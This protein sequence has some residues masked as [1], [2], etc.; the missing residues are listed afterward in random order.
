MYLSTCVFGIAFVLLGNVAPN[1]ISFGIRVLQAADKPVD[2]FAVRGIAIAVATFA[3][4]IHGFWRKG[5]IYL[6]NVFGLVKMLMLLVII[7]TGFIS[8]SGVFERAAVASDN[9][10]IHNA[11]KD[12]EDDPYG[13]AEAFLAILF[14]YGG[15]NQANYV[16]AEIDN[17][18][19][20]V[21]RIST[22]AM[23][24][25]IKVVVQMAGA[26]RCHM[27]F[28]PIYVRQRCI[29]ELQKGRDHLL[30]LLMRYYSS[31]SSH[32]KIN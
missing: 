1:S 5:G 2:N 28:Y 30:E 8:Y 12:P 4:L 10:N 24:Q 7:I 27:G 16:M 18:R 22:S 21:R 32:W 17:P 29:C 20:K 19:K 26:A 11:F 6:S 9:F 13:F 31:L 14:A 15:F 25:L 23:S 3:C